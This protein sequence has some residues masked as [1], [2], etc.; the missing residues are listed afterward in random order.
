MLGVPIARSR[1]LARL[2]EPFEAVLAD[3]VEHE[4][5]T[6]AHG[7]EEAGVDESRQHIQIRVS[8]LF[9]RFER[10]AAGE[11]REP[12]EERLRVLVEK[13]VAPCDRSTKRALTLG[14]VARAA[15]EKRQPPFQPSE[16]RSGVEQLGPGGRELEGEWEIVQARTDLVHSCIDTEL[17]SYRACPLDEKGCRIRGRQR[18][19]RILELRGDVQRNPARDEEPELRGAGE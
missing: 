11:H 10:K 3:R 1:S 9:G 12:S 15:C 7:L 17:T 13:V 4:Q 16:E 19:D 14:H 5:A 18:V 8:N 2:L 6:V